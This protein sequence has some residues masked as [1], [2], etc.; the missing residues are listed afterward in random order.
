MQSSCCTNS[1]LGPYFYKRGR[2]TPQRSTGLVINR[3]KISCP[4]RNAMSASLAGRRQP[5]RCL[6]ETPW[7]RPVQ[8]IF[9]QRFEEYLGPSGNNLIH[10]TV[11]CVASARCC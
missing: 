3:R 4:A 7:A 2:N 10:T 5:K 9:L 11:V 8:K 6:C 1:P